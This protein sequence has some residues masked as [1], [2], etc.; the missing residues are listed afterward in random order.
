MHIANNMLISCHLYHALDSSGQAREEDA[1]ENMSTVLQ[2]T[3]NIFRLRKKNADMLGS[4][5]LLN[6]NKIEHNEETGYFLESV[7]KTYLSKVTL[8]GLLP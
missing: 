2:K 8:L 7:Q 1:K 4:I 3:E 5:K 6:C